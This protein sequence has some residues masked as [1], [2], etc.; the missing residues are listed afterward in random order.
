M[1]PWHYSN[2]RTPAFAGTFK[3]SDAGLEINISGALYSVETASEKT[4]EIIADAMVMREVDD[5]RRY[6]EKKDKSLLPEVDALLSQIDILGGIRDDHAW[7]GDLSK[8]ATL[9][10]ELQNLID[11]T[12]SELVDVELASTFAVQSLGDIE[13][14]KNFD[15]SVSGHLMDQIN[16]VESFAA[17]A[18]RIELLYCYFDC[19]SALEWIECFLKCM[20]T[21]Q[22]ILNEKSIP[23]FLAGLDAIDDIFDSII[24]FSHLCV[25]ASNGDKDTRFVFNRREA[26]SYTNTS[27]FDFILVCEKSIRSALAVIPETG[28]AKALSTSDGLPEIARQ[29]IVQEYHI[30]KR[31][32]EIIAPLLSKR[33]PRRLR[34]LIFQYFREEV[35]HE[36]FELRSCVLLGVSE[37][38]VLSM[39]PMPL[40]RLY[41]DALTV[42]ARICPEALL[43]CV[44]ITEGLL[45]D[46]PVTIDRIANSKGL[47][48]KTRRALR[49]HTEVNL[50][51]NHS[52]LSRHFFS[53]IK[54]LKP[55]QQVRTLSAIEYMLELNYRAIEALGDMEHSPATIM[56]FEANQ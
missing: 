47:N 20:A 43:A 8:R 38:E 15:A 44:M 11:W 49:K 35:G 52:S 36:E 21:N 37:A 32:V 56:Q 12:Y 53:N 46:S 45:G 42:F 14:L 23:E 50:L 4:A 13:K 10:V 34:K 3:K 18:S 26:E 28:L 19:P 41:V 5:I 30:T 17:L 54:W 29:F 7:D 1:Q 51:L 31:F 48:E 6:V 22:R 39:R 25:L 33:T 16:S 55:I 40:H 2:M 27:G 9:L 24:I